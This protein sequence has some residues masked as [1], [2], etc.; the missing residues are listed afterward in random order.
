MALD[1]RIENNQNNLSADNARQQVDVN[2]AALAQAESTEDGETQGANTGNAANASTPNASDAGNTQQT[3][4]STVDY[5]SNLEASPPMIEPPVLRAQNLSVNSQ[6]DGIDSNTVL[7]AINGPVAAASV[8][9]APAAATDGAIQPVVDVAIKAA[10]TA[11]VVPQSFTAT[12]QEIISSLDELMR[13]TQLF[14][15][16]PNAPWETSDPR[17]MGFENNFS[18]EEA[19]NFL[20]KKLS[21]AENP[22]TADDLEGIMRSTTGAYIGDA[23]GYRGTMQKPQLNTVDFKAWY[24]GRA[25]VIAAEPAELFSPADLSRGDRM[26]KSLNQDLHTA[27]YQKIE[28]KRRGPVEG[29]TPTP[30]SSPTTPTPPT[31]PPQ[32][33]P[34]V[35]LLR[36]IAIARALSV[37]DLV[38][39]TIPEMENFVAEFGDDAFAGVYSSVQYNISILEN[40]FVSLIDQGL[41]LKGDSFA[42]MGKDEQM[43]ETKRLNQTS[44]DV[45]NDVVRTLGNA[46]WRAREKGKEADVLA[47]SYKLIRD[48][49]VSGAQE[50]QGAISKSPVGAS[51]AGGFQ[52]YATRQAA[53]AGVRLI[54]RTQQLSAAEE[55]ALLDQTRELM[56]PADDDYINAIAGPL[57]GDSGPAKNYGDFA[58]T[59]M[60]TLKSEF[61]NDSSL[62]EKVTKAIEAGLKAQAIGAAAERV[63]GG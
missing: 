48:F 62:Q 5:L 24:S 50:V 63:V 28:E 19:R 1:P 2:E 4:L 9:E 15:D 41:S 7:S 25:G 45:L 12:K 31:P 27:L 36:D 6:S 38:I 22:I 54:A 59:F 18:G 56:G 14:R 11:G 8:A 35:E 30:G 29:V 39:A 37:G 51:F 43:L 21:A 32:L 42:R 61:G 53:D 33:D 40:R 34:E 57:V 58:V 60:T 20:A 55:Q 47:N 26:L 13:G 16:R 52:T 49:T 23:G 10:A 17:P 46:S 44:T 3:D